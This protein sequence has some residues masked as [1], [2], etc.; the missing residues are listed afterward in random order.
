MAA[1]RTVFLRVLAAAGLA[2]SLS[3][4][5]AAAA[6]G[7]ISAAA[8]TSRIEARDCA[9]AVDELKAGLKQ[10]Y[11]EVSLLAGT[12]YDH[13]VCVQRDW[14]KAVLFYSQ[15]YQAGV[16]EAADRM[17]AGFAAPEN[18]ADVVA[19]LW[20]ASHGRMVTAP[21]GQVLAPCAASPAAAYDIDR[22]VAELKTWPQWQLAM[23][24]YV[25][26]VMSTLTAETKYPG[27]ARAYGVGGEVMLRFLPAVPRIELKKA[28]SHE[29]QILGAV[30]GTM[31][32]ERESARVTGGFEKMLAAVAERALA[33]YPQPAGI[34]G[35][36]EFALRVIFELE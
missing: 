34:P 18:G 9:G 11:A 4:P 20:W 26:G 25:A 22:F 32:R 1:Y 24:N 31:Q 21:G 17:A 8:V 2:A 16:K 30:N 35:E 27:R 10:G 33:R 5:C 3:L 19:A 13:G 12:M 29:Y 28:G 14:D 15:A 23:C 36:A 6:P 7:Q